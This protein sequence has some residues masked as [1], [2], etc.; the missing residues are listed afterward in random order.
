MRRGCRDIEPPWGAKGQLA[1][2]RRSPRQVGL[3]QGTGLLAEV[4]QLRGLREAI[5]CPS[6]SLGSARHLRHPQV[7]PLPAAVPAVSRGHPGE[8]GSRRR[9]LPA[10]FFAQGPVQSPRPP[11]GLGGRS[12]AREPPE[13]LQNPGLSETA[14]RAEQ[15]A[16][17]PWLLWA[18]T[19]VSSWAQGEAALGLPAS[20]WSESNRAFWALLVQFLSCLVQLPPLLSTTDILWLS[21]FCYPLL[22]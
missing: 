3:R 16:H 14:P 6:R 8:P 10:C 19:R 5:I 1:S 22:R 7:L 20:S 18:G 9:P 13:P 12:A 2:R 17:Q 4:R 15:C 21:C 11:G